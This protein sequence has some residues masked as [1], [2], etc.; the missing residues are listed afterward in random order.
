MNK[1]SMAVIGI[2]LIGYTLL[3]AMYNYNCGVVRECID[4]ERAIPNIVHL[5][6]VDGNY[7]EFDFFH[8]LIVKATTE[9]IKPDIIYLHGDVEPYGEWWDR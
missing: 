6:K 7:Y 1:I 5:V 8:W 9:T 3:L 2:L 4:S